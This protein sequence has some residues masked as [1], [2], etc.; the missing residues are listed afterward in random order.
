MR[1]DKELH[2][3]VRQNLRMF[4]YPRFDDGDID[5]LLDEID[6]LEAEA[7]KHRWIPVSERLPDRCVDD[8]VVLDVSVPVYVYPYLKYASATCYDYVLKKWLCSAEKTV[9]HWTF[10][11]EPP[12]EEEC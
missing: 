3:R 8:G 4:D 7:E 6:R 12:K 10:L 11:P 9:T 1:Y 5:A 2:E